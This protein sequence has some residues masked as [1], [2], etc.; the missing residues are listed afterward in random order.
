LSV[1]T[2]PV[3]AQPA[4]LPPR[5]PVTFNKDVAPILFTNCVSCHRPGEAAPFS[6]LTYEDAKRRAG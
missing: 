1:P 2:P 6:L 5:Q 4:N 3:Q